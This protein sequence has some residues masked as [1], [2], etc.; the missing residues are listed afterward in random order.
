MTSIISKSLQT[1]L[2]YSIGEIL[3][4]VIGILIALQIN[5]WNDTRKE[6]N[7]IKSYFNKI[8][9]EVKSTTRMID[10]NQSFTTDSM[11]PQIRKG[12]KIMSEKKLDSI[13]EFKKA[14]NYL[15]ESESLAFYFPI[16]D[17]F[18]N[19][20]Y[21]SKIE[22]SELNRYFEYLDYSRSQCNISD[23]ITRNYQYRLIKP[24]IQ[25]NI[26]YSEIALY[27]KSVVKGGNKTNFTLLLDD[28]ELWNLLTFQL[29]NLESSSN[30]FQQLSSILKK[31]DKKFIELEKNYR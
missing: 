22:D 4:V 16:I 1:Y 8:N 18:L 12:L 31:I 15:T 14:L 26:N 21:L 28:I 25:K 17:E 11:I 23:E 13:D 9:E 24:Y 30:N 29:E 19:Q 6:N 5:N 2:K 27:Q 20:G 7:K 3:L 10:Y